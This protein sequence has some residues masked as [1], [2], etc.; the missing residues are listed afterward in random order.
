MLVEIQATTGRWSLADKVAGVRW[1]SERSAGVGTAKALAGGFDEHSTSGNRV[2]LGKTGGAG[3]TFE[4]VDDGRG[5][6]IRYEG[7]DPADVLHVTACVERTAQ[8]VIGA[9]GLG[10]AVPIPD[11]VNDGFKGVYKYLRTN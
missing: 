11:K 1:P 4:L 2:R 3:V 8:I 5:L 9:M 6:E 7:K 10:G